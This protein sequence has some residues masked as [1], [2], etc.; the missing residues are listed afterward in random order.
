MY[1]SAETIANLQGLRRVH[2]LNPAAIRL[3]KSIGDEVGLKN[4]GTI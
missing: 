2:Q 4:I 3:D 1:I